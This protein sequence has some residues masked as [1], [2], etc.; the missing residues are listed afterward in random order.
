[1][2]DGKTSK[3]VDEADDGKRGKVGEDVAWENIK[4]F[5]PTQQYLENKYAI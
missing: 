5:G 3:N 4:M 2:R 1:M